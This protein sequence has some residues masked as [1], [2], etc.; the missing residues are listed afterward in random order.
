M[1]TPPKL[2]LEQEAHVL[3][4]AAAG[5]S[6]RWIARWLKSKHR[7]TISDVAVWKIL[8]QT[9]RARADA[10]AAT[11]RGELQKKLPRDLQLF[12]ARV[13]K[14]RRELRKIETAL[15]KLTPRAQAYSKLSRLQDLKIRELRQCLDT[16]LHYVGADAPEAGKSL[17]GI[18]DLIARG[19]PKS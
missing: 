14:L 18:A 4:H 7:I 5:K 6:T 3:E 2:T 12:E 1:P 9:R 11:V 17:D 10:A 19:F 15:G 16:K 13:A 8:R